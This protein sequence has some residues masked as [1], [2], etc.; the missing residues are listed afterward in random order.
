L[1]K[2]PPVGS[3]RTRK[4]RQWSKERDYRRLAD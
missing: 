3:W 4:L 2:P 1:L